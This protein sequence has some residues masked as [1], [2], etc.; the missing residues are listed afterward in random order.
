MRLRQS[1]QGAGTVLE[2]LDFPVARHLGKDTC[3]RILK[4]QIVFNQQDF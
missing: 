4:N 3:K 1:L 2:G